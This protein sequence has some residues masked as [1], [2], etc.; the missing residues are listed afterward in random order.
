LASKLT[1]DPK[2]KFL[3]RFRSNISGKFKGKK[4]HCMTEI[5]LNR[6]FLS[7]SLESNHFLSPLLNQRLKKIK[8]M[9]FGT[10]IE[11][12]KLLGTKILLFENLEDQNVHLTPSLEK[13]SFNRF[14]HLS[15]LY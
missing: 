10:K 2:I 1:I 12:H 11:F 5:D 15:L 13:P 9:N 3:F 6:D 4:A 14:F 8:K 7:L